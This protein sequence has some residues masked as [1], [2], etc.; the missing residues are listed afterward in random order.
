M[1]AAIALF[2]LVTF[3]AGDVVIQVNAAVCPTCH[4]DPCACG[5]GKGKHDRTRVGVGVNVDLSGVGRRQR[6]ADPFAVPATSSSSS[7]QSETKKTKKPSQESTS[8][9]NAFA[10]IKLTGP[11]TKDVKVADAT[12]AV[13]RQ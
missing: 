1:K 7:S 12:Q 10:G 8:S 9:G 2:T 13:S 6:E 4:S 11:Q 3:L 5:S